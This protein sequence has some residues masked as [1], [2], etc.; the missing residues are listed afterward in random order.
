VV[1]QKN[2][3]ADICYLPLSLRSLRNFWVKFR[4]AIFVP[5]GG[6]PNTEKGN[7][8]T[9]SFWMAKVLLV[10]LSFVCVRAIDL[11]AELLDFRAVFDA[12][13]IVLD[14]TPPPAMN[15]GIEHLEKGR[16]KA[17][18]EIFTRI[19]SQSPSEYGF[20]ALKVSC[21]T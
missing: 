19:L 20:R 15:V 5:A 8:V 13:N 17:A 14:K 4:V 2:K 1:R 16:A 21:T 12:R 11:D 18:I 3:R 6:L 7:Q 10:V 9:L